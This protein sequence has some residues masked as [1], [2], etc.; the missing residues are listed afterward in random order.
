MKNQEIV[1]RHFRE[2]LEQAQ[3]TGEAIVVVVP[4]LLWT[5]RVTQD[6]VINH[7]GEA[8]GATKEPEH[9]AIHDQFWTDQ[10]S[11]RTSRAG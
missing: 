6:G 9:R 1:E 3:M 5:I 8:T 4:G 11:L 10:S 2:L 7:R